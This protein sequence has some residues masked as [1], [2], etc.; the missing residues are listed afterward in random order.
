[1]AKLIQ[2]QSLT[3][4]I[5]LSPAQLQFLKLL[6]LTE[7]ELE[8][9]IE[10]ELE[11]NPAL[12]EAYQR[13]RED[14]HEDNREDQDWEFGDYASEDD[15]PAYK[16]Y[17]LQERQTRRE[18]IPFAASA[19]TLDEVLLNQL[20]MEGLPEAQEEVARYI[21]GSIDADGY[22]TRT[23][24]E[25]QD[26]L[27]FKA[28]VDVDVDT[29]SSLIERIRQLEPA[30]IAA[31]DLKDCLLL[32]LR[33][34]GANADGQLAIRM[35]TEHYDDFTN[36]RFGRLSKRMGISRD[37]LAELYTLIGRLNPKPASAFGSVD[38]DRMMHYNPDF[39]VTA[40][41]GELTVSLVDEQEIRPLRLSPLYA[42][43][44]ESNSDDSERSRE[45]REF[46]RHKMNQARWFIEAVT[47]RQSTLR[48][49][50]QAIV[51]HQR[52]F[53]LS[54]ETSELRPMILRDIAQATRMNISTISRVSNSKSV[55]TDHGVYPLKFFFGDNIAT[56]EGEEATNRTL[57]HRLQR[58]IEGEDKAKPYT[59][60]ELRQLLK[61]KGYTPSRRA[62]AKYRNQL[63]I[64]VAR[65][66]KEL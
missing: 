39:I 53:F 65:L 33:R 11:E 52:A 16:L 51:E 3:Q 37:K 24:E 26:D 2:E 19:P 22:L 15:I 47:R 14:E 34:Y 9:C 1:M 62:I 49:V 5:A 64:P 8:S 54:G 20:R 12:E 7:H 31:R 58:L 50:M 32:Q 4:S 55:Q 63:N 17:E 60:E 6:V 10:R 18:E 41:D 25:L 46:V 21:V 27:L 66:R 40:V 56:Q 13:D 48:L 28:S 36:K 44:L 61:E 23:A 30:G 42:E 57:K 45:A 35:L 59:D 29:I 43:M 38:E